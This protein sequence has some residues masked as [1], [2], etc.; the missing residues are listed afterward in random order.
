MYILKYRYVII[1]EC[2]GMIVKGMNEV[3]NFIFIE[4]RVFSLKVFE[5]WYV[6]KVLVK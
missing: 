2:C 3:Y 4:N 5:W 6:L 1:I